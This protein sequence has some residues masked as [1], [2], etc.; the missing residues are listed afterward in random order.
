M[1]AVSSKRGSDRFWDKH[2]FKCLYP[3]NAVLHF[4]QK[5]VVFKRVEETVCKLFK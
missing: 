3:V 2:V 4:T 5:F 1:G